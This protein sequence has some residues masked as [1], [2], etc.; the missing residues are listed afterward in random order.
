MWNSISALRVWAQKTPRNAG[1]SNLV[2]RIVI[3]CFR[4]IFSLPDDYYS[5][6]HKNQTKF[7]G[8]FK[9][10]VLKEK[11]LKKAVLQA[12]GRKTARTSAK[13]ARVLQEALYPKTGTAPF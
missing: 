13:L 5:I 11:P 2:R 1:F 6:Y 12:V 4:S 9:T 3:L 7:R 8:S 10:S